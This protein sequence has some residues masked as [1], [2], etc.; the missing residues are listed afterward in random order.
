MRPFRFLPPILPKTMAMNTEITIDRLRLYARHGVM[1]QEQIVG[2]NFYVSI[3]ADVEV[4]DEALQG[5][6]LTGTVNYA[7]MAEAIKEE[8]GR[9]SQLLEHVAWRIGK[10]LLTDFHRINKVSVHVEKE[11]PPIGMQ[12]ESIGIK[13]T[14]ERE[15]NNIE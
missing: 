2:A 8:M 12:T 4:S 14:L 7:M 15:Y 5:D 6:S 13:L 9:T 1:S 10:R 11:N 3:C